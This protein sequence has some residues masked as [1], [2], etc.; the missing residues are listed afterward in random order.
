[1]GSKGSPERGSFDES[2]NL[3]FTSLYKFKL[4]PQSRAWSFCHG[5]PWGF[6]WHCGTFKI[7]LL[8]FSCI[9]H[10]QGLMTIYPSVAKTGALGGSS[11]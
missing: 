9:R 10:T 6:L 5:S 11:H 7:I 3:V 2:R 4:R 1:M 8:S